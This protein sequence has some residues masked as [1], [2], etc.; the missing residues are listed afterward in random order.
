MGEFHVEK[1]EVERWFASRKSDDKKSKIEYECY[2]TDNGWLIKTRTITVDWGIT[3][4][5]LWIPDEIIA[6]MI[7]PQSAKKLLNE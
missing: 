3:E 6:I 7:K 2:Q 5:Q 4:N 1:K